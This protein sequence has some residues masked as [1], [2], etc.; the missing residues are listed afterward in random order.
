MSTATGYS[1]L[2]MTLRDFKAKS[3][4]EKIA[5]FNN[6]PDKL[7]DDPTQLLRLYTLGLRDSSPSVTRVA[8]Q[9]AAYLVLGLQEVAGKEPG[10]SEKAP[11]FPEVDTAEFQ[12]A[13]LELLNHR[14]GSTG[15][16]AALALIYASPAEPALER[17]FLD[18]L[19]H[20]PHP[21]IKAEMLKAMVIAGYQ[22]NHLAEVALELM[23]PKLKVLHMAS[24]VLGYLKS[25][26]TLDDLIALS[27]KPSGAQKFA[28]SALAAYGQDAT[29][30][31]PTLRSLVD[32]PDTTQDVKTEALLAIDAIIT[33]K[34][35]PIDIRTM[36]LHKIWPSIILR[37][38]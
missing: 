35:K 3:T 5:V 29:K 22:S 30:A 6:R 17:F 21:Q 34:G 28:I 11:D 33:G 2:A 24:N 32:S 27:V 25:P 38:E 9:S 18:K 7:I 12:R 8:A 26:E 37:S 16:P 23:D 14:D 36:E 1:S 13:L 4:A 31:V 15:A 10:A 19:K 20:E